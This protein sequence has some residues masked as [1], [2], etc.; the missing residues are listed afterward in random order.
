VLLVVSE[1]LTDS[2]SRVRGQEL[3]G[4]GIGG[5]GSYD[6]GVLHGAEVLEGLYDVG[7]SG[8]LLSNGNVDAVKMLGGVALGESLLL[9]NNSVNS[10]GGLSGLSISNDQLSLSSSYWHQGVHGLESSLHGLVHRLSW[11]N[12]WGLQLDSRSLLGL[13]WAKTVDWVSEGVNDSSKHAL[14]DGDI[15]NGS[16]SLDDITLLDLSIVSQH[17][18]SDVVSLEVKSHALNSR[19]ELNHLSGLDLHEAEDSGDTITD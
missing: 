5:S 3:Q 17:D 16:G 1:V 19:V 9:V 14:A 2:A 11:D 8:S 6:T 15:D 12:S 4:G 7:N 13:D 10:N 18:D